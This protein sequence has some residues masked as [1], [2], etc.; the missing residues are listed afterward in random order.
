M[1]IKRLCL[2]L[3]LVLAAT[4]LAAFMVAASVVS[5]DFSLG[6]W[7]YVKPILLPMDLR[8]EALVELFP[9]AEVYANSSRGLIDLRIVADDGTE[10]PFK[11]EVSKGE[12][13]RSSFAVSLRD[14]GHVSGQYTTFI[15]DLGREGVLHNEIEI[16]TP[17]SVKGGAKLY[18]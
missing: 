16:R 5:A 18:H 13:Q 1:K 11:R 9:D 4:G 3:K 6:D 7:R 2:R 15:A 8:D 14:K 12:R 10:V 17:S